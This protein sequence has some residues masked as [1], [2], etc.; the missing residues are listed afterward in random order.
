MAVPQENVSSHDTGAPFAGKVVTPIIPDVP[1][2][3]I[4]DEVEAN[5]DVT[6]VISQIEGGA[7]AS[8]VST[9][10]IELLVTLPT[11]PGADGRQGEQIDVPQGEQTDVPQAQGEQTDVPSIS[12]TVVS[13]TPKGILLSSAAN[14][15][16]VNIRTPSKVLH[17]S[18][19]TLEEFSSDEEDES[20]EL[21]QAPVV[22]PKTLKWVPYMWH[23]T[24]FAASKTL[25][26]CDYLGE[27]LAYFFGITS[28]KYQYA[29]SEYYLNT[30]MEE[31]R[32]QSQMLESKTWA[33]GDA[34]QESFELVVNQPPAA[35]DQGEASTSSSQP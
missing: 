6:Q 32:Q 12:A 9:N 22:D 5:N 24:V 20:K 11:S 23:Y 34:P 14:R 26:A 30:R 21:V 29:V 3:I 2:K 25:S 27:R 4:T 17:F 15:D 7:S 1:D 13:G 16:V 8:V 31:K 28:P 18:D 33:H 35:I 19:G 10:N